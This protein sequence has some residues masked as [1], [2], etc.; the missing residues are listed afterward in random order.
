ML[1][2]FPGHQ[3]E[4]VSFN[5]WFCLKAKEKKILKN[6]AHKKTISGEV[7][8]GASNKGR[9]I[10]GLFKIKKLKKQT[11]NLSAVYMSPY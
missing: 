9:N 7:R 1:F 6:P 3:S 2:V 11:R 10:Y 8:F 5:I 4:K